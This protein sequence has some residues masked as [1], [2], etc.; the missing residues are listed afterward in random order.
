MPINRRTAL[1][2]SA[3][4]AILAALVLAGCGAPDYDGDHALALVERQCEFGPRAPGSAGHAAM[5]DWMVA[6]LSGLA[7]RVSIQRFTVIG[8]EGAEIELANVI[9]SFRLDARERVLLGAHWDTRWV[10]ERDPEP[11][12]RGLPIPGANDGASGVAVLLAL[13]SMMSE[14]P[15]AVG[16]DLVFFDGEDGGNDGGLGEFCLGSTYYALNMGDYSPRYA[17]VIDMIGDADLR[18][19]KEPNSMAA[20]PAVVERV[21][22]AAA[23]VGASSFVS[24][25]GTPVYDDHVP[26]IRAGVPSALVI[27]FDYTYWHTHEDTPDKCSA[28]SLREVGA[29]LTELIY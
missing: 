14:H 2:I 16:V 4:A 24:E 15:P 23:D 29:V 27:D 10:A 28:E 18:I 26:L 8:S 21:W 7:D 12:N 3:T 1:P 6:E 22:E 19:P 13:A 11:A 9:A 17:V 5:L 25:A 20:C